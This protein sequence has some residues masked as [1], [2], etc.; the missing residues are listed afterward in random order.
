MQN[1][2]SGLTL[3]ELV[4]VMAIV[5][6]LATSG[7]PIFMH[8]MARYKANSVSTTIYQ[9]LQF[10]RSAAMNRGYKVTLCGSEDGK[11]CTNRSILKMLV[12][13]DEDN[14]HRLDKTDLVIQVIDLGLKAQQLQLKAALNRSYIEFDANGRARQSGSFNYCSQN[15]EARNSR[16]VVISLSGRVYLARDKD[17]DGIVKQANGKPIACTK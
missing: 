3:I 7:T 11:G 10:A 1:K 5:A 16:R 9:Q 17:G 2:F 15:N 14:N 8:L 6:I 13:K 12:F 4:S